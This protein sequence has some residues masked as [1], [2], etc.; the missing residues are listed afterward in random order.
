[1][2]NRFASLFIVVVTLWLHPS[3]WA[4]D[5]VPIPA[6]PADVVTLKDGSVIFGE[7]IELTNGELQI[8]T[9]FG[10][11]DIVKIKSANV[12]K[13]SVNHP[14]PFHLKQGTVVVATAEAGEEGMEVLK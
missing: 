7:V 13:L 11:G 14:L 10:V 4:E 3:T 5:P 12:A 8:K 9:A 6:P 1:M 2:K